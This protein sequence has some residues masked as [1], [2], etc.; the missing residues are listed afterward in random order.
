M[1]GCLRA[2]LLHELIKPFLR[3]FVP[4]LVITRLQLLL[5]LCQ[6][7]R[8]ANVLLNDVALLLQASVLVVFAQF[9]EVT[10]PQVVDLA[11]LQRIQLSA[12]VADR[13]FLVDRVEL[14]VHFLIACLDLQIV[15]LL[16]LLDEVHVL[17]ILRLPH[18]L[19]MFLFLVLLLQLFHLCLVFQE[20]ALPGRM[21]I[22]LAFLSKVLNVRHML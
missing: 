7:Y 20:V 16:L 21:R 13:N 8:H 6:T 15:V 9:L 12:L 2:A 11:M 22:I 3:H 14:I 19:F 17:L 18:H 1:E 5:L 4:Q 10:E